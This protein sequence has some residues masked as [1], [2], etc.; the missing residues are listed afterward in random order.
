MHGLTLPA[1]F[2]TVVLCLSLFPAVSKAGM[3]LFTG[4]SC[5][6]TATAD[7]ACDGS[8]QR[9]DGKKSFRVRS[10]LDRAAC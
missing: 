4:Q 7:F 1:A 5:T 2:S 10:P 9:F 6:G 8:C 3:T